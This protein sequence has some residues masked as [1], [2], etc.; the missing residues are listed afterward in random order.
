MRMCVTAPLTWFGHILRIRYVWTTT[1]N[2]KYTRVCTA[3]A[4]RQSSLS[5]VMSSQKVLLRVLFVVRLQSAYI[6][7][8]KMKVEAKRQMCSL[9]IPNA[10][11]IRTIMT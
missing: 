8:R 10:T 11:T 9:T 4:C 5:F 6:F 3:T 1:C 2:I 7:L